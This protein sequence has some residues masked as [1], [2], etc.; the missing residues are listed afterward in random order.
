MGDAADRLQ[1]ILNRFAHDADNAELW[2]AARELADNFTL[3]Q[4]CAMAPSR[5][6]DVK[7]LFDH[8][9]GRNVRPTDGGPHKRTP[10]VGPRLASWDRAVTGR[11]G[12]AGAR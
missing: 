3:D 11:P 7:R 12:A 9:L 8:I 4:L 10:G 2:P 5:E 1:T 6:G